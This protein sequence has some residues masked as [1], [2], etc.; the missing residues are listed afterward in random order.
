MPRLI[1]A[2]LAVVLAGLTV[3]LF[4]T[5]RAASMSV[6]SPAPARMIRADAQPAD[7][8]VR[9][10]QYVTVNFATLRARGQ[11]QMLREPYLTFEFF[12]EALFAEFVRYDANSSGVTWVGR[13]EGDPQSSVT[14]A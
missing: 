14:L 2:F 3:S 10:S 1:A 7:A 4:D 8:T 13:V 12:N 11:R 6:L 9:R 5:T